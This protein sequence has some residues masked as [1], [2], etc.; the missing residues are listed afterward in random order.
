[1][2]SQ[3]VRHNWANELNWIGLSPRPKL[4]VTS[5][6]FAEPAE[7]ME[8]PVTGVKENREPGG[9]VEGGIGVTPHPPPH[10]YLYMW[11]CLQIVWLYTWKTKNVLA[12]LF[13][14]EWE[15][16]LTWKGKWGLFLANRRYREAK[17]ELE[18]K[19]S[20]LS[21]LLSLGLNGQGCTLLSLTICVPFLFFLAYI[22]WKSHCSWALCNVLNSAQ[23]HLW[24]KAHE[25]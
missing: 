3:R 4:K 17:E 7:Q 19:G 5:C 21:D 24:K 16:C 6:F 10:R 1:M 8:I 13:R 18:G 23:K 22:L 14:C 2:G 20:C 15:S 11:S 12:F 25:K 9:I